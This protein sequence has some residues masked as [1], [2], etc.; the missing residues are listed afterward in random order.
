MDIRRRHDRSR[1]FKSA[2]TFHPKTT[3]PSKTPCFFSK[4]KKAG[5]SSLS[6]FWLVSCSTIITRFSVAVHVYVSRSM[7]TWNEKV[8]RDSSA[9]IRCHD[10]FFCCSNFDSEEVYG[11]LGV[12][13]LRFQIRVLI[14][15]LREFVRA[16]CND[17]RVRGSS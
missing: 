4:T 1:Y 6:V 5:L 13:Y 10:R 8:V 2:K 14:G 15:F 12:G 9:T 3:T 16:C 11:N 17:F 7:C